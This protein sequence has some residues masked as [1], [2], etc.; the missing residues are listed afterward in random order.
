MLFDTGTAA[1]PVEINPA[2]G[3]NR[4]GLG[5][6]GNSLAYVGKGTLAA[7]TPGDIFHFDLSTSIV[8]RITNDGL[9]DND[10]HVAPNGN[11]IVWSRCL[12]GDCD[13]LQAVRD[14]MG[15]TTSTVAGTSDVEER[16]D[17]NGSIVV[18]TAAR[19]G[20]TDLF[21]K[22]VAGGAEQQLVLSGLQK[23][24]S[25]SGNIVSFESRAVGAGNAD[26]FLY[27]I[28]TGGLYQITNTPNVS[29]SLNDLYV[30]PDGRINLVWE[31]DDDFDG[32]IYGATFFL[33]AANAPAPP[34]AM[35]LAL[36]LLGLLFGNRLPRRARRG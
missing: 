32:N 35:L 3:S 17:T 30:F 26:I 5:L 8:T 34:T 4:E 24:P 15:W 28:G 23:N 33:P 20:E 21:W 1:P 36:G 7:P 22:S 18:Y 12:I 2:A 27:D 14:G 9:E 6:G 25:I 29:E 10:L 31:A 16:A 13:V 11:V 19:A